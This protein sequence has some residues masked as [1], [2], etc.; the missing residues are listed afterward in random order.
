MYF[1]CKGLASVDL[2]TKTSID[3][4]QRAATDED[5]LVTCFVFAV[6]NLSERRRDKTAS[7]LF[8]GTVL[9]ASPGD[10]NLGTIYILCLIPLLEAIAIRADEASDAQST[11]ALEPELRKGEKGLKRKGTLFSSTNPQKQL[12]HLTSFD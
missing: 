5:I 8:D 11:I 10:F 3:L 1:G 2:G 9:T 6:W 12:F 7:S 4:R